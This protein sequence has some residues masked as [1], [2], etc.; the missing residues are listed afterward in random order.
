MSHSTEQSPG[1][2]GDEGTNVLIVSQGVRLNELQSWF[3]GEHL[4]ARS[5]RG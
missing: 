3:V 4:A 1:E 5:S 2:D